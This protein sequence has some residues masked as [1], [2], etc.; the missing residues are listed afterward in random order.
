MFNYCHVP[1]TLKKMVFK[2]CYDPNIN[3]SNMIGLY[4]LNLILLYS[5]YSHI[6]NTPIQG[7]CKIF[8]VYKNILS[9]T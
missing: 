3:G 7:Y 4:D 1:M 6:R 8:F 9:K 5:L 2:T